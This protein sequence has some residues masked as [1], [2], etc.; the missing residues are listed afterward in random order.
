MEQDYKKLFEVE[1]QN[2]ILLHAKL[3]KERKEHQKVVQ[4]LERKK[5]ELEDK[6][7]S[8]SNKQASLFDKL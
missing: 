7:Y 5:K 3:L 4:E 2:N 6:I 8:L 1:K